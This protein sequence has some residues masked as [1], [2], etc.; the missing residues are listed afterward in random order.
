MDDCADALARDDLERGLGLLSSVV[1]CLP[2]QEFS[3]TSAKIL[4]E[5]AE[6]LE[7]FGTQRIEYALLALHT[8]YADLAHRQANAFSRVFQ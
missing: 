6:R 1:H 8:M 3:G 7:E 2:M 5:C 4:W